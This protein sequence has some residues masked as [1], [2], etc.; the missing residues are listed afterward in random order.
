MILINGRQLLVSEAMQDDRHPLHAQAKDYTK[1]VAELRDT[2][3]KYIK[4]IRPGFPKTNQGSDARGNEQT[5]VEPT[6]P[7]SF[8]LQT[9]YN[10]PTRGK[11]IWSCCLTTPKL[12]P[13]QLWEM[14]SKRSVSIKDSLTIDVNKNPDL[15]YY[16]YYISNA[17]KTDRLKVDNPKADIKKK[18]DKVRAEVERKTAI[19]NMLSDED[20]LRRMAQAYNVGDTATK[21]ADALRFELEAVLEANDKKKQRDPSVKGTAEFLAEMKVTDNIRLRSFIK[22]LLDNKVIEYKPDGRFRIGDKVLCQVTY[23]HLKDTFNFICNYYGAPNNADK[24]QDLMKDVVTK[25][26]LDKF[27]EKDITW[28]AKVMDVTVAFKKKE[29]IKKLVYEAF[30]ITLE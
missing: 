14:G 10:H 13:N 7:A 8:P 6:P 25:E 20:V 3:G 1:G 19:W 23:E 17:I 24:L 21:D 4:L 27:D 30:S 5:L 26:T 11:E 28:M 18:A 2:F 22:T 15:A 9:E 29:E 16:F 12:L